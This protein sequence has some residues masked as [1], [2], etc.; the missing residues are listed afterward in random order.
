MIKKI[1]N[2][3]LV[4]AI[5][6]KLP[7]LAGFIMLP[8]ITPF[9]ENLDYGIYGIILS[10]STG[11][12]VIKTLGLD[13]ILMNTYIHL[14]DSQK[15]K[16]F[17]NE[18][19]GFIAVWSIIL[20]IIVGLVIFWMLPIEAKE[21]INIILILTVIPILFY[22]PLQIIATKYYQM[23]EKPIQIG[24]RSLLFG[25][26]SV[27]LTYYFIAELKIGYL[28]WLW[29]FFITETLLFLSYIYPIWIREELYPNILFRRKA[30]KRY[31]KISLP[32]VPH[33]SAFFLLDFSDRLVMLNMGV[34]TSN[35]GLYDFAYRFAG[36]ARVFSESIHQASTPLL[37]K[38]YKARKETSYIKDMVFLQSFVVCFVS[39]AISI[40]LKE[41]FHLMVKNEDLVNTYNMGIILTMSYAYKPMYTAM[42]TVF[43][44]H[45]KTKEFWKISFIAGLINIILNIIFIPIY[46]FKVAV[47][48]TF[49][50][51]LYIGYSGFLV[52]GF[53]KIYAYD[54]KPLMWVAYTTV[55]LIIAYIFKDASM[56]LKLLLTFSLFIFTIFNTIPLIK[57]IR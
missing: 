9:L 55:L 28:G 5:L 18:I 45:E 35:I 50:S 41:I 10:I 32:L 48:T 46:G 51:F 22:S 14:Y 16:P 36:Y 15:F 25:V 43:Y 21:N 19:Q 12:T 24:Y 37:L 29:S 13:V 26:V 30:I 3:S 1:I 53:K 57:K 47:I 49:I 54:F 33:T 4:Y 8:W 34:S 42:A 38:E 56:I 17:W 6:P 23:A 7:I 20:S 52:T 31:L 27:V 11:A 39:F 2:H 44:Y 40:W